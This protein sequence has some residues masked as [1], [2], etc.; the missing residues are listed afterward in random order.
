MWSVPFDVL[1]G[2]VMLATS[3]VDVR[4]PAVTEKT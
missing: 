2:N 1:D 4:P 3:F